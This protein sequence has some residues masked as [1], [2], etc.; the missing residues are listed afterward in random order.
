MMSLW[1]LWMPAQA[2]AGSL[3]ARKLTNELTSKSIDYATSTA[4]TDS[5]ET[6]SDAERDSVQQR[7]NYRDILQAA[8][9]QPSALKGAHPTG[10]RT[11]RSNVLMRTTHLRQQVEQ[12]MPEQLNP[13]DHFQRTYQ[14]L[15]TNLKRFALSIAESIA[16]QT[17][18]IAEQLR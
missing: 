6:N 9:Q 15:A 5:A 7:R 3:D 10:L 4:E 2:D 17:H 14:T 13:S 8:R 18:Q 1:L 11:L 12:M 16:T